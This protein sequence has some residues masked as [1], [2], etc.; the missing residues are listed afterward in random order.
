M[1]GTIFIS[2]SAMVAQWRY[3]NKDLINLGLLAVKYSLVSTIL[4]GLQ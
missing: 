4:L 1:G 2:S 3:L